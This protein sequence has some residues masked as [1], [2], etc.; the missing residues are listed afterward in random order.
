VYA[1]IPPTRRAGLHGR[2]AKALEEAA[3]AEREQIC[4]R[5]AFHWDQ[6]GDRE[7]AVEFLLMAGEKARRQY[8]N[9][10]AVRFFQRALAL[11]GEPSAPEGMEM[12][13]RALAG[14]GKVH[15]VLGRPDEMERCFRRAIELAWSWTGRG[16]RSHRCASAAVSRS[17][18]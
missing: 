17:T 18:A 6:G 3:G 4:E 9:E 8:V 2:I 16:R 15:D 5:L 10:E 13:L 12:Q 1:A 7:K 14:M 11:L